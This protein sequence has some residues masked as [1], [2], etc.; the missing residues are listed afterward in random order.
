MYFTRSISIMVCEITCDLII[1]NCLSLSWVET[2]R[3]CLTFSWDENPWEQTERGVAT[4][5]LKFVNTRSLW[6]VL[7]FISAKSQANTLSFNST[8][9]HTIVNNQV[10]S[11]LSRNDS[12]YY[13]KI[14]VFALF[15]SWSSN[16]LYW[17]GTIFLKL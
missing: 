12:I 8:H 13:K 16:Q 3:V 11:L 17:I 9:T 15:I 2:Q 1:Y 5:H 10:S 14:N 4:Y 6:V 7:S